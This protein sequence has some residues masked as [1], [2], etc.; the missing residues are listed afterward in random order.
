[1]HTVEYEAV[2]E[3]KLGLQESRNTSL[4]NSVTRTKKQLIFNLILSMYVTYEQQYYIYLKNTCVSKWMCGSRMNGCLFNT[5]VR[6]YGEEGNGSV[7]RGQAKNQTLACIHDE[8]W[9]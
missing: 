4:K 9:S 3:R 1:M 8:S 2:F 6:A 5:R 7:G